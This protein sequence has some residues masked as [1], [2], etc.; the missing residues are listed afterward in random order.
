MYISIFF[1]I[2]NP[3]G[4][5]S[6]F[7][8]ASSDD[9]ALKEIENLVPNIVTVKTKKALGRNAAEFKEQQE[10]LRNNCYKQMVERSKLS[11]YEY[12]K[13]IKKENTND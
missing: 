7:F 12:V 2:S 11:T 1:I 9:V 3:L 10:V 8:F 5:F 13:Y 6:K 4:S